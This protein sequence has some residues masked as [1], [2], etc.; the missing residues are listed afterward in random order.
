MYENVASV[1]Y[2]AGSDDA[3][4]TEMGIPFDTPKPVEVAQR[5]I[6]SISRGT[7]IV[8]DFFAGSGTAAHAVM[9]LN[10]RDG[11]SRPWIAVQLP[12]P[13]PAD[14]DARAKGF[15]TVAAI[16]LARI[17]AAGDKVRGDLA[18]QSVDTGF[19]KYALI[20]TNFA[21]WHVASD[22]DA[23]ALEQHLLTLRGSADDNASTEALLSELL[24]KQGYSLTEHAVDDEIAGLR[25]QSVGSGLLLAYLDEHTKPSLDQLR[26]V[27]DVEPEQLVILEDAFHGDDEL[28]TNL[29]QLC[30]SKGVELWTA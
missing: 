23:T 5:L 2:Y 24:L 19:R 25:L 29:A 4:L 28:K 21:K 16:A 15:E 9:A 30:K 3:L 6:Q 18:G 7:D 17:C 22:V 1:L 11:G 10:A 14:S 27:V 26:A 13:T 20:D 12:E 8:L